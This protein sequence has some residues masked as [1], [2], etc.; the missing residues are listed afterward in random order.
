M[1]AA[2]GLIS[3]TMWFALAIHVFRIIGRPSIPAWV[4][5]PEMQALVVF[6]VLGGWTLGIAFV[7]KSATML[8]W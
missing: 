4:R 2:V 7:I 6:V 5:S 1:L 8:L 3:G